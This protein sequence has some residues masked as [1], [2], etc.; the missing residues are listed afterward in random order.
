M[1]FNTVVLWVMALGSLIGG[2]D[3]ICGNHLG[4][5]REFEKGYEM[6]GPLT[7]G[8]VGI[9]C[10]TPLLQNGIRLVALPVCDAL[11]VDPSI[12][13]AILANDMGGYQ[14]AMELAENPLAG[15]LSGVLVAS[16]LGAALVFNIPVGLGIIAQEKHPYF[17]QGLLIGFIAIP[18]GSFCGGLCAGFPVRLVWRTIAPVAAISLLLAAGLRLTPQQVT[19]GCLF[20]GKLVGGCG[21]MGLACAAFSSVTGVTLIPGMT[22]IEEAMKTV[23]EIAIMLGGVFPILAVLMKLLKRPLSFAERWLSL[24]FT[25]V[26]AII[27]ALAN[28][29]SVFVMMKD[30]SRREIVI[31]TAWVMTASAALGDHL[32]F[33]ASVEP[34]MILALVAAKVSGGVLSFLLAMYVTRED[35]KFAAGRNERGDRNTVVG[36]RRIK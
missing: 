19:R 29:V 20:F 13:G 22:P 1:S 27:L 2:L 30:M 33:T 12:F 16:T 7:L 36:L 11:R 24:D 31:C 18:F 35:E 14:L 25:G 10:L 15:K 8:M 5:G 28:S 3:K 34:K 21:C 17:V 32:G 6:M 4:L 23:V 9:V 26:S